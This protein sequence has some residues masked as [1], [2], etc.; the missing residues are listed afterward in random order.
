MS[1]IFLCYIGAV[2]FLMWLD[3]LGQKA[4]EKKELHDADFDKIKKR[5]AQAREQYAMH[6]VM[7][8]AKRPET[9]IH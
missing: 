3:N 2:L 5:F 6:Y 8:E 4:A 9:R 7:M 1:N